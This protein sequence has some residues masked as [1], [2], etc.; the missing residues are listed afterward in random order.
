[1]SRGKVPILEGGS[2]YFFKNIF[3]GNSMEESVEDVEAMKNAR[4]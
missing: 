1:M 3:K 4:L 2:I